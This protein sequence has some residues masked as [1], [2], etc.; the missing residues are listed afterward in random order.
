MKAVGFLVGLFVIVL[1]GCQVSGS[2]VMNRT[3]PLPVDVDPITGGTWYQPAVEATWQWQLLVPSGDTLNTGYS[4]DI[5]DVDLFD[6]SAADIATL[7]GSHKVI[8]YFSAGSYEDWRDDEGDFAGNELGN[9]LDGWD[10]ERW[11]DIRST[12]VHRIMKARLDTA[13][14]KGC[15]GVEPDNMDGYLNDPGFNFTARDQLAYNRFIANE[16]HKRN[17]SV[18]LKNDLDQVDD[19]VEY[20][21]FSVNEQCFQYDECDLLVP[22][23]NASKPVLNAEYPEEDA[24]LRDA[25][26]A[27]E[28]FTDSDID[29]AAVTDLCS[30]SNTLRFSTLVLPLNLDDTFRRTCLSS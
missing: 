15:D 21:D 2:S 11:L 18:G 8:C 17:L 30:A 23:I 5:Y 10:D 13:V 4:V 6:T 19:L 16:A 20:Y 24:D 9:T 14:N 26:V 12:N 25:A 3:M 22:F 29:D 1:S 28:P 27:P 7:K